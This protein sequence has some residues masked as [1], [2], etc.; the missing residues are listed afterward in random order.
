MV[1]HLKAM[2]FSG[3]AADIKGALADMVEAG[4]T[5]PNILIWDIPRTLENFVSYQALEEV[6]NG[7]FFSGKFHG[8]QVAYNPRHVVVFAN[9]APD[10]T[11]MSE[12]RWK[13]VREL[14][15]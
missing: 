10:M 11:K 7:L 2:V 3:K 14:V 15:M 1:K 4:K 5:I 12:D 6:K 9:F 13:Y 8:T